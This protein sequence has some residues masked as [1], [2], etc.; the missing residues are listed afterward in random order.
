[1][2]PL[3]SVTEPRPSRLCVPAA[4]VVIHGLGCATVLEAGPLF[5]AEAAT[6]T[7]ASAANRN[8]IITGS[9]KLVR[10]PLIE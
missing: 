8:E 5:P 1:M 6:K 4:T 7:P 9:A 3:P 2:A 10:D